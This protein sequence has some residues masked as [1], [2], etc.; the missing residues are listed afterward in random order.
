MCVCHEYASGCHI[1]HIPLVFCSLLLYKKKMKSITL[2]SIW[3]ELQNFNHVATN[4]AYWLITQPHLELDHRLPPSKKEHQMHT[5]LLWKMSA[6]FQMESGSAKNVC[7]YM[8]TISHKIWAQYCCHSVLLH[9]VMVAQTWSELIHMKHMPL[10]VRVASL[11]LGQSYD[12]PSAIEVTLKMCKI[13]WY[14]ATTK[15]DR[16]RT[17]CFIRMTSWKWTL[18]NHCQF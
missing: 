2:Y 4:K 18:G 12:C 1:L 17:W 11:A 5:M 7:I 10:T 13:S 9:L 16:M 3:F 15:Y 14:Q 6:G 8:Y